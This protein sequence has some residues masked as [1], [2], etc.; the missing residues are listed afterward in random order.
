[1]DL[2]LE[3]VSLVFAKETNGNDNETQEDEH[4]MNVRPEM[5]NQSGKCTRIW[6]QIKQSSAA[7]RRETAGEISGCL[8]IIINNVL[9]NH[10]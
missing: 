2:L 7:W 4:E 10:W 1:M 8:G 9:P 6:A 5:E 3:S